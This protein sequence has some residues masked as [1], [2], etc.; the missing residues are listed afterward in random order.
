MNPEEVIRE[1]QRKAPLPP[2]YRAARGIWVQPAW[3]VR[4]LVERDNWTVSDA[5]REVISRQNLHPPDVAFKGI[6]AA[7]Y[8]VRKQVWPEEQP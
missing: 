8:E 1:I 6:R 2:K 5:V 7:Y 3:V 4:G